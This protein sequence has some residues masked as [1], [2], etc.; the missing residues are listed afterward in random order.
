MPKRKP[1]QRSPMA[2]A[3][4]SPLFRQRLKPSKKV[5]NRKRKDHHE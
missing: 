2:T 3:L 1:T 5:Y 4:Q